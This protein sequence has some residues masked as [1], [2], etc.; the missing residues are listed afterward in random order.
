MKRDR[1]PDAVKQKVLKANPSRECIYCSIDLVDAATLSYDHIIPVVRGGVNSPDNLALCCM[2]CNW[3]KNSKTP[4]EFAEYL[5]RRAL[6]ELE[7]LCDAMGSYFGDQT[8]LFWKLQQAIEAGP[9]FMRPV[10][11]TDEAQ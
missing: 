5:R 11:L 3:T 10:M 6:R 1:I 7:R 8:D 9:E 4:D 2:P